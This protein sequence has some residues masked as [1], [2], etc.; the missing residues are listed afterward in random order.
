VTNIA[1][2]IIVNGQVRIS[3]YQGA[4]RGDNSAGAHSESGADGVGRIGEQHV[5]D[6]RSWMSGVCLQPQYQIE[7]YMFKTKH[8]ETDFQSTRILNIEAKAPF[9]M[10]KS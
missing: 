7:I 8:Y 4:M 5:P 3:G 10:H 2:K 1:F 9:A 6:V